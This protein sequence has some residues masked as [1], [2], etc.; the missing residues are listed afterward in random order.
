MK[1]GTSLSIGLAV[2]L[3]RWSLSQGKS[4]ENLIQSTAVENSIT[5]TDF[6]MMTKTK[7]SSILFGVK[8][9]PLH[10][11]VVIAYLGINQPSLPERI[12]KITKSFTNSL[13]Y[14]RLKH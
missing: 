14:C 7:R 3:S 12:N 1:W 5:L 4:G 13:I 11:R 10:N 6:K 8:L 9:I 2:S